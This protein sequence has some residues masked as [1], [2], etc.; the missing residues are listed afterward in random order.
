MKVPSCSDV[1][2]NNLRRDHSTGGFINARGVHFHWQQLQS[3]SPHAS[4]QFSIPKAGSS[5]LRLIWELR[6]LTRD[7]IWTCMQTLDGRE[8]SAFI[9]RH[10]CGTGRFLI[11]TFAVRGQA[12]GATLNGRKGDCQGRMHGSRFSPNV[13]D[14][15][16]DPIH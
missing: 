6:R 1:R 16:I 10:G 8:R 13:I 11:A 7:A 2:G 5:T 14:S 3:H 15:I 4:D 12:T 9:I